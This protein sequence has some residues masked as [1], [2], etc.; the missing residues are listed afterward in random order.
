MLREFIAYRSHAGLDFLNTSN[1]IALHQR[2]THI[3]ELSLQLV[4]A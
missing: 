2:N 1:L 3:V 4:Q